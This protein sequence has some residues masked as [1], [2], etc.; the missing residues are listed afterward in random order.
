MI[1]DASALPLPL[2]LKTEVCV[3]GSGAG[4]GT[5]AMAAAEAGRQVLVLEAGA[6]VPPAHMSQREE[7]MLPR[8]LYANGSQTT[9]DRGVRVHQ[10]RAVGGSTVHNINL[11]KRI[12][13]PVLAAWRRNRGLS[14]L[15]HPTWDALYAEVEALIRVGPVP[16]EQISRH[17]RLLQAGATALGWQAGPLRHNRTGCADSGFCLLGCAYD[18]KNNVPRV[19]LPRAVAAGVEVLSR[20]RAVRILHRHGAVTGVQAVAL[21]PWTRRPLGEV[22]VEAER[23]LVAGSAT[24]TPALLLRSGVPDPSGTTGRHLHIHP[25]LVAAGDFDDPVRAAEGIPQSIEVTEWLDF[26]AAHAGGPAPVGTRTWIVPAF[27]QP[28]GTATQL[29]GFGAAHRALMARYDHIA[30]FTGMVH[31]GTDGVVRPRGDLGWSVDYWPDEADR[32]ELTFGLAACAR[33]LQAAGARR[34]IIPTDPP[35]VLQPGDDPDVLK[36]LPLRRGL[37]DVTGVHPMGSVPMGDDPEQAAV[38]SRG[39]HHH[40]RGLW[41]ADGSIFPTSIGVPPQM[42]IYAMGLHVGRDLAGA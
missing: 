28:M 18:A 17:N 11:C 12:P 24:G 13:S 34:V 19:V 7:Q 36:R 32:A 20:C 8:L 14:H 4:G 9:R 29:P 40:L 27:A 35:T 39:R 10:G 15:P 3:I 16:P 42:S 23:V 25:A 21:D 22:T 26:E 30:V 1:H 5:A 37:L 6:F 31:D 41:I 38:D 2:R 33:L